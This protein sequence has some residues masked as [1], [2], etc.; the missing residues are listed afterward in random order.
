[1]K[2]KACPIF[3]AVFPYKPFCTLKLLKKVSVNKSYLSTICTHFN[4]LNSILF[5]FSKY[6]TVNNYTCFYRQITNEN[7]NLL[8]SWKLVLIVY[9]VAN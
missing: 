2:C 7:I 1:M 3:F 5:E 4:T 6:E 9:L 8:F